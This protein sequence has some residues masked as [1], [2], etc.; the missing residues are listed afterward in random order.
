MS[1][2]YVHTLGDEPLHIAGPERAHAAAVAIEEA[3]RAIY[4]Q[5]GGVSELVENGTLPR[6]ALDLTRFFGKPV[7]ESLRIWLGDPLGTST[8]T[9]NGETTPVTHCV[10]NTAA[11]AGPDPVALLARLHGSVEHCLWADSEDAAW[12][13]GVIHEG[14]EAGVLREGIGW[15][16]VVERLNTTTSPVVLS[17]STGRD[18]PG[19]EYDEETDEIIEPEDP[20]AAWLAAFEEVK[21]QGW[22]QQLTPDNLRKPAYAPLTTFQDLE[23]RPQSERA[24]PPILLQ[25]A[26]DLL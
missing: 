26:E 16:P 8:V 20:Q 18:F 25:R 7:H 19:V 12:L 4:D 6:E 11:V 2:I 13:A 23:R 9:I 10:L 22:W 21:T 1:A 24:K 5:P 14:R 15:E 17:T 3:C